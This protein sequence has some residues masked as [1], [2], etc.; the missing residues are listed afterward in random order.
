MLVYLAR[1]NSHASL[2]RLSSRQESLALDI[3]ETHVLYLSQCMY[4]A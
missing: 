3:L 2:E 4:I 1:F